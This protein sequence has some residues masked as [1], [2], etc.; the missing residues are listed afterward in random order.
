MNQD[1]LYNV[2]MAG[3]ACMVGEM[4]A[5]LT[6][7]FLNEIVSGIGGSVIAFARGYR[8]PLVVTDG[9]LNVQR[10]RD[11]ILPHRVIL[12]FHNTP[13]SRFCSMVMSP[14]MQLNCLRTN[15]IDFTDDWP[16]NSPDLNPIEHVGTDD[17]GVVP[18]HPL[19]HLCYNNKTIKLKS[20]SKC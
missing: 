14:F 15:N 19:T 12:L 1:F 16:A 5:I 2:L 13:T 9:N 6:V 3:Y 17:W 18:T 10:Y 4:N 20:I 7:V 11:D 8:S